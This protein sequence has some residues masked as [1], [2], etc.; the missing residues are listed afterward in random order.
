MLIFHQP[1]IFENKK[2]Y[3]DLSPEVETNM[4]SVIDLL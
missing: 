1:K 2:K 3:L 4:M